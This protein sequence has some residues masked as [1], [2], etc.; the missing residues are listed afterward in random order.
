MTYVMKLPESYSDVSKKEMEYDGGFIPVWMG[1]CLAVSA[2]CSGLSFALT[3]AKA[4]GYCTW[5]TNTVH[6]V[7]GILLGIGSAAGIASGIGLIG[8][9]AGLA[10]TAA[11]ADVA[12]SGLFTASTW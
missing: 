4:A 3:W 12:C 10:G 6:T 5:D 2:I 8:Y 7:S 1:A 9:G 11:F